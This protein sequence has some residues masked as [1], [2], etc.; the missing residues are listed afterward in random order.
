M[1]RILII[2]NTNDSHHLLSDV[3]VEHTGSDL[4]FCDLRTCE[5]TKISSGSSAKSD[6]AD[7]QVPRDWKQ[8][9]DIPVKD[10]TTQSEIFEAA[11]KMVIEQARA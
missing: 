9:V 5:A 8:V 11:E 1:L 7:S 10:A 2:G 6:V 4:L 3:A